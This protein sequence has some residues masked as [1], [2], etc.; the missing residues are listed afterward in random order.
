MSEGGWT[1]AYKNDIVSDEIP[2]LCNAV[3]S[4]VHIEENDS[5]YVT[6]VVLMAVQIFTGLANIAYYALGMSYLDDNTKKNYVA[7]LIGAVLSVKIIGVCFGY[8]LAWQ[9]LR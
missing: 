5:A 6:I 2:E 8:I 1:G 3:S 9:C 7:G 4:K